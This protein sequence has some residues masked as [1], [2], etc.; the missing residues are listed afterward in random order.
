VC[1]VSVKYYVLVET[2]LDKMACGVNI[3]FE[4]KRMRILR[5]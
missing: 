2:A 3:R 5:E 1:H 4:I